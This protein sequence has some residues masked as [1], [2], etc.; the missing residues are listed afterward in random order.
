MDKVFG[1]SGDAIEHLNQ[2]D[3]PEATKRSGA[4]SLIIFQ[5]LASDADAKKVIAELQ[6]GNIL[7]LDISQ[8]AKAADFNRLVDLLKDATYKVD[9]DIARIS[10]DKL[11]VSP[12]QVKVLRKKIVER[13]SSLQ[14]I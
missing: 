1:S 11:I 12:R 2:V 7:V 10:N 5:T 13:D 14:E 6:Q 8:G 9:G 3:I 4:K